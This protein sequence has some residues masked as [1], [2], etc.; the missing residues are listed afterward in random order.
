VSQPPP[1]PQDPVKPCR[2]C[3]LCS[4]TLTAGEYRSDQPPPF[5]AFAW[6]GGTALARHLLDHPAAVAHRP[7]LDLASGSGLVAIAALLA[8]ASAAT[9]V[10]I[11]PLAAAAIELNAEANKVRVSV[12]IDD[13]LSRGLDEVGLP[14]TT[15]VLA[16]DV[17]YSQEMSRRMLTF[18][19]R[20]ARDGADVL[21][22]DP[23]RAY[24]PTDYFT[25]LQTIDV[26]VRPA[27]ESVELRSVTIYRINPAGAARR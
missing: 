5:W 18:L 25:A 17:F 7:V 8:G 27:L 19:R 6:A 11:D 22:G 12:V 2:C 23:G 1:H 14:P 21:V 9:A 3:R 20:A 26:P 15:V 10:E 24:F 13:I 16:G 4:G